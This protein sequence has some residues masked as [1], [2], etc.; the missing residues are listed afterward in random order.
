MPRI[1]RIVAAGY[2]HHITQRGNYQQ[3][4]FSDDT[5]RRKYLLLLKEES[6]R[7][8]LDHISLLS[9]VIP[10]LILNKY[11]LILLTFDTIYQFHH[12]Y[13][14]LR[15]SSI[16]RS[17]MFSSEVAP[18]SILSFGMHPSEIPGLTVEEGIICQD[19]Y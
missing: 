3:K 8:S 2:P 1:A 10:F 13:K 7:L 15:K 18:H 6:K 12:S 5:D 19:L 14:K 17:D 11:S 9:R 4:I 16:L